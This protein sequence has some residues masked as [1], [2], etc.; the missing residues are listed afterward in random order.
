MSEIV[1]PRLVPVNHPNGGFWA[2]ATWDRMTQFGQRADTGG[3]NMGSPIAIVG[4][5]SICVFGILFVVW[6]WRRLGK[7]AKADAETRR[8][9]AAVPF[10]PT[11]DYGVYDAGDGGT[12]DCGGDAGVADC[13]AN[14]GG[15]GDAG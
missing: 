2:S 10:Q 4:A 14:G 7:Q 12:A 3:R 11:V 5:L 1:G 8:A 13:S 9:F 6:D 15:G